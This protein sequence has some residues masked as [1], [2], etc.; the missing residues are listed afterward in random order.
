MILKGPYRVR[1]VR[2]W[3]CRSS[4]MRQGAFVAQGPAREQDR[5]TGRPHDGRDLHVHDLHVL[6]QDGPI[7]YRK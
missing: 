1:T 4:R 5:D 7:S 6:R 3:G 2:D